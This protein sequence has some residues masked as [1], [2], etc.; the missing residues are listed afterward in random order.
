MDASTGWPVDQPRAHLLSTH[1][2]NSASCTDAHASGAV[3][4]SECELGTAHTGPDGGLPP[5]MSS[6][7]L[8]TPGFSQT[9]F[10]LYPLF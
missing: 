8:H 10:S 1:S 3:L 7:S 4:R 6:T 9:T 2:G 5:G